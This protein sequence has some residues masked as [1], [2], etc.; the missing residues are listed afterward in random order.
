MKKNNKIHKKEP[1]NI[2]RKDFVTKSLLALGGTMLL[3]RTIFGQECNLTSSDILGPYFIEGAPIQ[4]IIAHSDEPGQRLFI[5]GRV[6]QNDCESIIAGAM[7]EVW[8]ANDAGCYSINQVCSTGNPDNEEFNLRGKM[9]SDSNGFYGFETILPGNYANRPKHIHI[10]ITTPDNQVLIS[11]I[12][13]EN[14]Q[15]CDSDPWCQEADDRVVTLQQTPFGFQGQL[16]INMNSSVNQLLIGDVNMDGVINVQDIVIMVGIILGNVN[17]N[18]FQLYAADIN[19]DNIVDVLDIVSIVNIILGT[20][21]SY[22]A[23]EKGDLIVKD[24][25]VVLTSVGDVAGIQMKVRGDFTITKNLLPNNWELYHENNIILIFN[26]NKDLT[27]IENLF[28]FEGNLDI[29]SNVIT[30]WNVE[31]IVAN[32][33]YNPMQFQISE[34]YPNP[35]N[36]T[37]NFKFTNNNLCNVKLI[38][39]D[40]RGIELDILFNQKMQVGTF[41]FSWNASI[42]PTGTYFIKAIVGSKIQVKKVQL[43]K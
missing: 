21:Q 10:K 22:K 27:F 23:L 30:G 18:D 19:G 17:H 1:L 32:I 31:R 20:R 7:V 36:P 15:L 29:V 13:F 40:L 2:S 42:Y 9:F 34:P 5:T 24:K 3:P 11:Q 26:N 16:D 37:V 38:V 35:F 12:Y 43:L 41:K 39:Y 14:D 25:K 33:N 6:L 8:H 4:T 28:E